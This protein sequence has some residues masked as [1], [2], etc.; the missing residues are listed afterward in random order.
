MLKPFQPNPHTHTFSFDLLLC[1][2]LLPLCLIPHSVL[3]V[4]ISHKYSNDLVRGYHCNKL[5]ESKRMFHSGIAHKNLFLSQPVNPLI[6]RR[7]RANLNRSAEKASIEVFAQNLRNLLLTPPCKGKAILG[8][9]P[10]KLGRFII[11]FLNS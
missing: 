3:P 4:E 9:D 5:I 8:I 10:G 11:T 7:V 2:S 6:C 1:P